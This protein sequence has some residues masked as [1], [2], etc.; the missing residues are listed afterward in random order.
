M[1]DIINIELEVIMAMRGHQ[2][3][4]QDV[5]KYQSGQATGEDCNALH[6]QFPEFDPRD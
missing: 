3:E 2:A 6:S 1:T 4:I 5:E